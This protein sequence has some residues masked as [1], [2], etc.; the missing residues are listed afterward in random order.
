MTSRLFFGRA[1]QHGRAADIDVFYG[2][3]KAAIG[4]GD[5]RFEGVEIHHHHVDRFDAVLL[6]LGHVRGVVAHAEQAAVHLGVQGLH[7]AIEHLGKTGVFRNILDRNTFLPQQVGRAARRKDLDP[8]IRQFPGKSDDTG[9]IRNTDQRALD[10][11]HILLSFPAENTFLTT[12]AA[13][14]PQPR[15]PLGW[16]TKKTVRPAV[17]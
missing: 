14:W 9:F 15:H 4:L 6:H 11:G 7:P 16:K 17:F 1:A 13:T 12:S 2:V 3:F 5:R 8:E 10:D